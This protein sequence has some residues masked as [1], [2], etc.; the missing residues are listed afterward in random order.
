MR[1]PFIS[2]VAIALYLAHHSASSAEFCSAY[3]T[4]P[5]P[6]GVV[7]FDLPPCAVVGERYR[8]RA[9]GV[10][11]VSQGAVVVV[12]VRRDDSARPGARRELAVGSVVVARPLPVSIDLVRDK[13][14]RLVAEP[15]RHVARGVYVTVSRHRD[16]VA[17]LVIGVVNIFPVHFK[18]EAPSTSIL[19][20][21]CAN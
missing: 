14:C 17:E 9:V 3:Q 7:G 10:D 4:L 13:P 21:N 20:C 11:G 18:C 5:T 15:A 1:T 2:Q 8:R 19:H 16:L 12:A 6:G